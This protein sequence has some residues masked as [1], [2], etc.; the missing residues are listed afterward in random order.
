MAEAVIIVSIFSGNDHNDLWN[1]R[2]S[3]K[4]NKRL[5]K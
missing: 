1:S 5:F 4:E 3:I 2:E